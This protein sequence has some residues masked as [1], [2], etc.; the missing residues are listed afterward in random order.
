MEECGWLQGNPSPWYVLML[1]VGSAEH[2]RASLNHATRGCRSVMPAPGPVR[3]TGPMFSGHPGS[4]HP[5]TCSCFQWAVQEHGRAS[6]DHA[7][8]A[9]RSVM[10]APGP[11]RETGSMF[12]G[13]PGSTHPGTCSSSPPTL[14]TKA[15]STLRSAGAL[16]SPKRTPQEK[17]FVSFA[18][19]HR[20][21][22]HSPHARR[23]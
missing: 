22:G 9:C 6:L 3:E 7:T 5:G 18:N 1:S 14:K 10:P 8:R 11:V 19:M 17:Q 15:P 13:R 23:C 12:S 4:T 20:K 16:Q 21:V 2:G